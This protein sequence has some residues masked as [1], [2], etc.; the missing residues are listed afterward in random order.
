M[1]STQV[2]LYQQIARVLL[3]ED[4]GCCGCYFPYRYEPVY[5][6]TLT[7]NKGTDNVLLFEFY[8]QAQKPV[9]ITG[10]SFMFRLLNSSN[11]VLL[12]EKPMT[13]LNAPT[14]R[15]KVT[16]PASEL[17]DIVA[18]P[19]SYSITVTSGN[20]T[21]AVLTDA[22][23]GAS[24]PINITSGVYPSFI[25]S[26][27][28]IIPTTNMNQLVSYVGTPPNDWPDWAGPW[29]ANS[30]NWNAYSPTEFYSSQIVPRGPIT[31][32]QYSLVGYTGTVKA[33]AAQ[34]YQ[35]EWFDVSESVNFFNDT[36]VHHHNIMGWFPLLRMCF[37]N[38]LASN[39]TPV[40]QPATAYATAVDGVITQI[41]LSNPGQGYLAPPLITI[42]GDGAGA[43][44][45]AVMAGNGTIAS[46]NIISG[47][48]GY[49][50]MVPN[51][52]PCQ[53]VISTGMV[54]ALYA[55]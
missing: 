55:R 24:A 44:A 50:P 47:G 35:S 10:S 48:S 23:A 36:G 11:T 40:V 38:S 31:T 9:N 52:P 42:I 21:Q 33:Q 15:V 26:T 16:I 17:L 29:G 32:V 1:Y 53:I 30:Y 37:N 22:S 43:V 25:P 3:V 7:L 12:L 41:I 19:A 2:Y 20:L 34:D 6:K 5:A 49:R 45:E 54:N 18:Q 4:E 39:W 51:G 14:G 46:I 13:I 28:V 8:N 27:P